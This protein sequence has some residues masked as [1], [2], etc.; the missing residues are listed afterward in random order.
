MLTKLRLCVLNFI[1]ILS[2]V[3]PAPSVFSH[4]AAY[5]FS[6]MKPIFSCREGP[7]DQ[8][9]FSTEQDNGIRKFD[10]SLHGKPLW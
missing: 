1:N 7:G 9:E 4:Y 3:S 5:R 8:S 2:F 6:T 10:I